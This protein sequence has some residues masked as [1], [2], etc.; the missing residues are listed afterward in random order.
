MDYGNDLNL[1]R[2]Q[3]AYDEPKLT[4]GF[5]FAMIEDHEIEHKQKNMIDEIVDTLGVS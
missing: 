4:R 5:S 1:N 2:I 3:S